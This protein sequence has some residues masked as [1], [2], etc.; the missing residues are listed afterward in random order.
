MLVMRHKTGCQS[1]NLQPH[2]C[3]M[4]NAWMKGVRH[5]SEKQKLFP[6]MLYVY[7]HPF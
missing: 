3:I 5:P 1:R 4:Q 7:D 2:M 6:H